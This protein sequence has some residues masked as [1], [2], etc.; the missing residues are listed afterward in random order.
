M[1]PLHYHLEL[2]EGGT[3]LRTRF[4]QPAGND[5]IAGEL[6]VQLQEM[7]STGRL[8]GGPLIRVNGAISVPLAMVLAHHLLHL[9]EAVAVYDPKLSRYVVVSSHGA[10]HRVGDLID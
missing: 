9:Y 2:T 5:L 1:T 8:P 6:E 4:G 10:S 7:K 3:L